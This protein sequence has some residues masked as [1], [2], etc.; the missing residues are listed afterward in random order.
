MGKIKRNAL[1]PCGSGKKYKHCCGQKSGGEQTSE[2]VFKEAVQVQKDLMNYAFS[3]HQRAI[4]QFI[5]EFSFLADMDKETQQISVFHLSVW[6]IFFRPLT[7][8]KETIFQEFL[9]KK[10]EDITRP[11]TRQVVQSWTDMEPSLLLLNE[12][13]DESLYFENMITA[14]KVEVDVKPDQTVLPE[15]GSLVLG[16]PVQ[17]EEKAEFFIQYTMFAK[18]FTDTLLLQVRQ[19]VDAYEANGG[20]RST[21]MRES[22]PDVLK[23]MFAKQEVEES[24][25]PAQ[26][27][28]DAGLSA[29]RMDW[30]SDVQLETAKLIEDGMKEHGDQSLTD[31]ALTVWKAYCDQKSPVIRKAASFAAGIEYYIHSLASDAPLSQAQVAKKYG[32]SASTVSSRFKDIEKAV[33]EEQEATV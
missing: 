6:G 10:A 28:G 8:Q 12:K 22:F 24:E 19:L 3:K 31:G 7:D 33:K 1:C 2:L 18:E 13:T 14:E 5:N 26:T 32:I 4:N 9:T 20:E 15:K 30:A 23:C 21:F 11:K 17:F 16:F 29:D 25:T 27:E